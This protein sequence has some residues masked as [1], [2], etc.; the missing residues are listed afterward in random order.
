M[1]Y[2]GTKLQFPNWTEKKPLQQA[3]SGAK[4][5][6]GWIEGAIGEAVDVK[7]VLILPG[8]YVK[9]VEPGGIPV[10][11]GKHVTSSL[12]RLGSRRLL[13]DLLVK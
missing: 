9:Q 10:P 4:W 12:K 11:S 1:K 8:G 2:D 5:I 3:V 6:S 13:D 7:P